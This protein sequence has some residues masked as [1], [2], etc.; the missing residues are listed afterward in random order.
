[1]VV[2]TCL[3]NYVVLKLKLKQKKD[4]MENII[5]LQIIYN[6]QIFNMQTRTYVD[7]QYRLSGDKML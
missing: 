3:F 7:V 4:Q 6:K 5:F 1:M 2:W